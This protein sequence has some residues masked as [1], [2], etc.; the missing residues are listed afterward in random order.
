MSEFAVK[1]ADLKKMLGIAKNGP[2]N[3]G[4]SPGKSDA[5]SVLCMHRTKSAKA[6]GTAA[7]DDSNG[8]MFSY[9]TAEVIG[10]TLRLTCERLGIPKLATKVKRFLKSQK[11]SLNVEI[12]NDQGVCLDGDVEDDLPDDPDLL[13]GDGDDKASVTAATSPSPGQMKPLDAERAKLAAQLSTL[14]PRI[15]ALPPKLQARVGNHFKSA[16][17][18]TKSGNTENASKL[19]KQIESVLQKIE[20]AKLASDAA[21]VFGESKPAP[22][23]PSSPAP[24]TPSTGEPATDEAA[25]VFGESQASPL[26]S[27]GRR[28]INDRMIRIAKE[29]FPAMLVRAKAQTLKQAKGLVDSGKLEEAS[30]LLNELEAKAA[31][32]GQ[33]PKAGWQDQEASAQTPPSK[34]APDSAPSS[35]GA[36]A[37]D[38]EAPMMKKR[39]F[40]GSDFSNDAQMKSVNE[41]ITEEV[42][43]LMNLIDDKTKKWSEE[44][45]EPWMGVRS[46]CL[47]IINGVPGA[48]E[49][50]LEGYKKNNEK[51][52]EEALK[53]YIKLVKDKQER[54]TELKPLWMEDQRKRVEKEIKK[55]KKSSS[56]AM[57]ENFEGMFLEM[58]QMGEVMAMSETETKKKFNPF[59]AKKGGVI[60]PMEIGE[61]GA[62]YGY[63][64]ADYTQI[65]KLLRDGNGS[66]VDPKKFD[67]YIQAC[68]S[69]L[70]KLPPFTGEAVRCDKTAKYFLDDVIKTGIRTE[71]A[72]MSTGLTKV[73]GF[74]DIETKITKIT[75]GKNITPF[76]LHQG[77]GEVLF[78]PGS[79]FRF[80]KFE[81]THKDKAITITNHSELK[82]VVTGDT[83]KGV[84]HFEQIK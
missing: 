14:S 81:G 20:E 63:S 13:E 17:E 56:K 48:N 50:R 39:T 70:E 31:R 22:A 3:F 52:V 82:G 80:K 34:P 29:K 59:K 51:L 2:I 43:A 28:A 9:G 18:Q 23:R 26:D 72:F 15:K 65:N 33:A 74:G 66:G 1:G 49:S 69:G 68:K 35:S 78:P 42:Y 37:K 79:V 4:F 11:A 36:S 10:K 75:S 21:S 44:K 77:E 30:K 62:I 40:E 27:L 8:T 6:L 61:V 24:A 16:I 60:K 5:T 7:K 76:S 55:N 58:A 73:P 45:K 83:Q 12:F 67:P 54:K 53:K 46:G 57:L 38:D 64:T 41:K 47:A 32:A 71:K 84:F 19:L 25:A